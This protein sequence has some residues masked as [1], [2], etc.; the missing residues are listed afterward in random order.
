MIAQSRVEGQQKETRMKRKEEKAILVTGGCRSGKSRFAQKWAEERGES[1]LFLAT[2]RVTDEEMAERIRRHQK[3]RRKCW[4]TVEEPLL[5][6]GVLRKYGLNRD[7]ILVDCVTIW[8][9]NLL[10][11]GVSDED[12]LKRVQMV[13][14]TL[15]SISCSTALVTNEVGW[16]IVPEHPLG[17]RFRD[18][19][20]FANQILAESV[21]RVV[22]M[23]AGLP[24]KVK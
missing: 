15:H 1:R 8:L 19:A 22:L 2:A 9:S 6:D 23:V 18:L 3:A 7:V 24:M 10:L 21:D 13:S 4:E 17:R 16:G 14:K 5:V 12:I 11:E 20:G